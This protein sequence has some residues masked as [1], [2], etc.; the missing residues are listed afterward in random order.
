V[1]STRQQIFCNSQPCWNN[2]FV[3]LSM[4]YITCA[5]IVWIRFS[6]SANENVSIIADTVHKYE[7]EQVTAYHVASV[8]LQA[9]ERF[10]RMSKRGT[11]VFAE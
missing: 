2:D 7:Y 1:F 3:L 4:V 10:E 5:F 8:L 9:S 11:D 6:K